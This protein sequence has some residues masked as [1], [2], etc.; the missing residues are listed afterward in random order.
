MSENEDLAKILGVRGKAVE[1]VIDQED[2]L[3]GMIMG[4]MP[5]KEDRKRAM[6]TNPFK[7]SREENMIRSEPAFISAITKQF[8]EIDP[9]NL[10]G[11]Y[12][13]YRKGGEDLIKEFN[14]FLD[15][16][17]TWNELLRKEFRAVLDQG[18][19]LMIELYGITGFG[20]STAAQCLIC[21][22]YYQAMMNVRA[23][24]DDDFFDLQYHENAPFGIYYNCYSYTNGIECIKKLRPRDS[25]IFDE[26]I[27]EHGKGTGI[28]R[29]N[30]S[31]FVQSCSRAGQ[32]SIII[33]SPKRRPF[34]EVRAY[35]KVLAL[36]KKGNSTLAI[37]Y[38]LNEDTGDVNFKGLITIDA[39]QPPEF[40]QWYKDHSLGK[41]EAMAAAAGSN[42]RTLDPDLVMRLGEAMHRK[43]DQSSPAFREFLIAGDKE[44]E[45]LEVLAD[46]MIEIASDPA[47]RKPALR[48]AKFLDKREKQLQ[49]RMKELEQEEAGII[50]ARKAEADKIHAERQEKRVQASIPDKEIL[51]AELTGALALAKLDAST[52]NMARAVLLNEGYL[53]TPQEVSLYCNGKVLREDLSTLSAENF[54]LARMKHA[55]ACF[56]ASET[57]QRIELGMQEVFGE[58]TMQADLDLAD[59]DAIRQRFI[60]LSSSILASELPCA[61]DPA[62]GPTGTGERDSWIP[63]LDAYQSENSERDITIYKRFSAGEQGAALADEY[64]ID[65]SRVSTITNKEVSPWI[66][67]Q[68]ELQVHADVLAREDTGEWSLQSSIH[69]GKKGAEKPAEITTYP[70]EITFFLNK[71]TG[72]EK[73][74][75]LNAKAYYPRGDPKSYTVP[76]GKLTDVK[77]DMHAEIQAAR[78]WSKAH[79][80]SAIEV[81]CRFC[82]LYRG[83]PTGPNPWDWQL[84]GKVFEDE[85]LDWR[86]EKHPPL[87]FDFREAKKH[88]KRGNQNE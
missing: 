58:P 78:E 77:N 1:R 15:H 61:E 6:K 29:D 14:A 27:V 46:S 49:A 43:L 64:H 10:S 50:E 87:N 70:D 74:I 62:A 88:G 25:L 17:K 53:L 81:C 31:N 69:V 67:E 75:F 45:N 30:I 82:W 86:I 72:Q 21:Y 48:Y 38:V 51:S 4:V 5:T 20:K 18:R 16:G 7:K 3:R 52:E 9:I 26:T 40:R 13:A 65:K 12:E 44:G 80:G 32:N 59:P 85:N 83:K 42:A 41:K 79:P 37:L 23:Y 84:I 68:W 60:Q 8:P 24:F 63:D 35:I 22:L 54:A 73:V 71:N 76:V 28:N 11:C 66:A 47:Y 36:N 57:M 2:P 56:D 34:P 19:Q 55:R 39:T 33:C